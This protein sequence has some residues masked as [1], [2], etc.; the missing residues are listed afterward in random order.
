MRGRFNFSRVRKPRLCALHFQ[1]FEVNWKVI[2]EESH[3]SACA[4]EN[5]TY[6][7]VVQDEGADS[8]ALV[9]DRSFP[10]VCK[11]DFVDKRAGLGSQ[12]CDDL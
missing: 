9:V 2:R 11:P 12:Q 10:A 7:W 8:S 1:F 4:A 6:H 5:V 3:S